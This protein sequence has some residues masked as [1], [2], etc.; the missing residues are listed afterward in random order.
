MSRTT[1]WVIISLMTVALIGLVGFQLYWINN[2]IH[3]SNERFEKDVQ[4]SL[5][6]VAD[7]L[8]KNE[9]LYLVAKN[10]LW[11]VDSSRTANKTL[12]IGIKANVARDTSRREI[13]AYSSSSS[14]ESTQERLDKTAAI[15]SDSSIRVIHESTI[16]SRGV[17][18]VT[19][20]IDPDRLKNKTARLEVIVREILELEEGYHHRVHPEI[21]DSLLHE[22][23]TAKGINISY[24]FG[25][26]NEDEDNFVLVN[27]KNKDELLQSDLKANLFPNDL[28]GN[29]NYLMVNFPDQNS[30]LLKQISATLA[31]S[32][33]LIA[34]I[35]FCFAYAIHTIMRQKKLSEVKND[36]INNMTHEF[37]T[38]IATVSLA[39]EALGED[40]VIQDR[41]TYYRYLKVI[42]EETNRLSEQV[43]KVLQAASFDK[44]DFKLAKTRTNIVELVDKAVEKFRIQIEKRKGILER[45]YDKD[46]LEANVD[47]S[48]FHNAVQNLLD[49][50]LKYSS[51]EPNITVTLRSS[52]EKFVLSIKDKGIGIGKE[53]IKK[54]FDKFYRV[55]KGNIHDIKGFG[56]GL[57]YVKSVVD[58]HKGL[59]E[60]QSEPG[61]GSLF[62]LK[63]PING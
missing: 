62:T 14:S 19:Y 30:F 29:V 63:I 37:K 45:D 48:H 41:N 44:D 21:L 23:F 46:T 13:V 60:V 2:V 34:I 57:S 51:D 35:I 24:E 52:P 1:I 15:T 27:A 31:S 59:I 43:E 38:P 11:E 47:P 9:M 3:L 33:G 16:S 56:L 49:N 50:A 5:R 28:F 20:D 40:A 12:S 4:E 17:G 25:V 42:K 10:E 55:Q 8:E 26:F 54:I 58:A 36:F 7:K 18:D 22:E 32:V 6:S 39:S 61:K 53:Q